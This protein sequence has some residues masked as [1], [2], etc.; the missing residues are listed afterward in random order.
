MKISTELLI[1]ARLKQYSKK[2]ALD[3]V[4]SLR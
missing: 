4:N 3:Y 1:N 2:P